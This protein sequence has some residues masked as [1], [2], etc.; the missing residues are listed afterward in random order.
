MVNLNHSRVVRYV[1]SWVEQDQD[2]QSGQSIVTRSFS[3]DIQE[4]KEKQD[5]SEVS[6]HDKYEGVSDLEIDFGDELQE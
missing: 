6:F 5:F 1:T 3:E 4:I 2:L